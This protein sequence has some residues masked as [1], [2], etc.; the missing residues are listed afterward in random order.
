MS[1]TRQ[2]S[3]VCEQAFE[4]ETQSG[5][6]PATRA[7][8]IGAVVWRKAFLLQQNWIHPVQCAGFATRHS[9]PTY[10]KGPDNVE[11]GHNSAN[12]DSKIQNGARVRMFTR[13]QIVSGGPSGREDDSAPRYQGVGT[14]SRSRICAILKQK[15]FRNDR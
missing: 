11:D 6:L 14:L 7:V 12:P 15:P 3:A 2:A 8:A 9:A 4:V 5:T 1:R 13:K 10:V